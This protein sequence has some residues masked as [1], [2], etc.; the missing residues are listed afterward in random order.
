MSH[1]YLT[2]SRPSEGLFKDRGSRFMSYAF[3]VANEADVKFHLRRLR[4]LHPTA[5]HLCHTSVL[6]LH[7][8]EQRVNDDG[9]PGGSAGLPILNQLRS[10]GVT[11]VMVAVA[12]YFG[13]MKLGVP[14]LIHAY[15]QATKQALDAATV[16]EKVLMEQ[17]DIRFP[18][19]RIG[20]VERFIRQH[21]KQLAAKNF[22]SDCHWT[23]EVPLSAVDNSKA[24]LVSLVGVEVFG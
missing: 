7:G 1:S 17:I 3:P 4:I 19:S 24:L 9:E 5:H 22:G 8:E 6:G 21:H 18:H 12:R 11:Y 16:V 23:L 13:G 10:K 2:I 20:E 14:R 15:K